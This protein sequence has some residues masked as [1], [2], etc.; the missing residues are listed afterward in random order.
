MVPKSE[1]SQTAF[2]TQKDFGKEARE[3]AWAAEQRTLHGLQSTD[4]KVFSEKHT[5]R[6]IGVMAEEARRR[7]EIARYVYT[8]CCENRSRRPRRLVSVNTPEST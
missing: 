2:T 3:A 1:L 8:L 7:A 4:T 6:D 5:F